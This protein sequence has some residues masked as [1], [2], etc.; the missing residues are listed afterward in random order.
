LV[1][2]I[3]FIHNIYILYGLIIVNVFLFLTDKNINVPPQRHED[4]KGYPIQR[5]DP[6]KPQVAPSANAG[7]ARLAGEFAMAGGAKPLCFKSPLTI[8]KFLLICKRK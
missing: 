7:R 1:Y 5:H 2:Q 8:D 4:T 3:V 6:C